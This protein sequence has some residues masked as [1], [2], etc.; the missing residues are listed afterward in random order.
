MDRKFFE[1]AVNA[2]YCRSDLCK[3]IGLSSNGT[4]YRKVDKLLIEFQISTN[5]FDRSKKNR[6]RHNEIRDC[7]VCKKKFNVLVGSK[8]RIEKQTCGYA[9]AN[10]FFRSGINAP[11][12]K[13]DNE[14]Q[15]TTICWRYHKKKC[16]VCSEN[17]I[18]S[19]HHHDRNHE[20]NDP[21]NLVPLCP[22]HHQ[23]V[24]SRYHVLVDDVINVYVANFRLEMD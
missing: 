19:V 2:A 9:C 17:K 7:P 11:N 13:S 5:H 1:D 20:N 23:Y 8:T 4:G 14:S 18:V 15:Y 10:T 24:H 6:K 3:K 22:T 16:V 21:T 12:R